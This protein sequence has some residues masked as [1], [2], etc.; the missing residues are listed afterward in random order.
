M[1]LPMGKQAKKA[2]TR[3]CG[4]CGAAVNLIEAR[5]GDGRPVVGTGFFRGLLAASVMTAFFG[6]LVLIGFTLGKLF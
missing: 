5:L 3:T 2:E 4:E 6:L 1:A